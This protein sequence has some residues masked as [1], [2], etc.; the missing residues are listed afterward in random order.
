MLLSAA[1]FL[2]V[3]PNLRRDRRERVARLDLVRA[4]A[5]AWPSVA[6]CRPGRP[7]GPPSGGRGRGVVGRAVA[8]VAECRRRSPTAPSS[9]APD[10]P[11]ASGPRARR[12]APSA[13]PT[14]TTRHGRGEPPGGALGGHA[15]PGPF[16]D[17]RA[18]WRT[19]GPGRAG[20]H[21]GAVRLEPGRARDVGRP[22]GSARAGDPA[23]GRPSAS[24][25]QRWARD[26]VGRVPRTV[27]RRGGGDRRRA[28][29]TG[30]VGS[31]VR[32]A[33]VDGLRHA[34]QDS[35][36]RARTG[37]RSRG[38]LGSRDPAAAAGVGAPDPGNAEILATTYFP[39]RLPSQYLRRWR[40]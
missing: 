12:S 18:P 29:R 25:R 23:S 39:E 7:S 30:V 10:V 40:A 4:R 26:G 8:A 3:V 17:H 38:A 1:S 22:P 32:A 20:R 24:R 27:D 36:R 31:G 2:T 21:V 11:G 14:T 34:R 37:R 9:P 13:T 19:N 28:P 33:G 16:E 6:G 5:R 35:R 15:D